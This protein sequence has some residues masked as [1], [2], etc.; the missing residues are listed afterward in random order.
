MSQEQWSWAR[1]RS[2]IRDVSAPDKAAINRVLV[3]YVLK[4]ADIELQ[5]DHLNAMRWNRERKRRTMRTSGIHRA[6]LAAA[7]AL[8]MVCGAVAG[9]G[10]PSLALRVVDREVQVGT[11]S[12]DS[13]YLQWCTPMGEWLN[14]NETTSIDPEVSSLWF[15]GI[16][17]DGQTGDPMLWDPPSDALFYSADIADPDPAGLTWAVVGRLDDEG[18]IQGL[19][20][21]EPLSFGD[22]SEPPPV[23]AAE[24]KNNQAVATPDPGRVRL[25]WQNQTTRQPVLWHLGDS[26]VRK[27]GVAVASSNPSSAWGIAGTADI[28]GDGTEDLVWH[29]SSTGRIIIWFLDPDGVMRGTQQVRDVNLSTVWKIKGVEDMNRDGI[30]DLVFH[31]SSTGRAH[32]WFLDDEGEYVSGADVAAV[33]LDTAWQIKGVADMNKDANPDLI[34]HHATTGRAHIWF[35]NAT[36]NYVSGTNV[37]NVNLATSWKIKGVADVNSDSNPDLV[38]HNSSSGRTHT[39]FLNATGNY[40]SGTNALDTNLATTWQINAVSY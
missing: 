28:D 6:M 19:P 9:S 35:L 34:W 14:W 27:G 32:I 1:R 25:Y 33:N 37:A 23:L 22:E 7:A 38:W 10:G 13:Y 20:A 24:P 39:W 11:E 30:P 3:K 5:Y 17:E 2:V 21:R 36:G 8:A 40:V 4:T 12:A 18:L 15:R 16:F 26:G 29:N 31:N